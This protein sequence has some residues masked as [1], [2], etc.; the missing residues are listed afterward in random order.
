MK[1]VKVMKSVFDRL[2]S[3]LGSYSLKTAKNLSRIQ[4]GIQPRGIAQQPEDPE[5]PNSYVPYDQ[6]IDYRSGKGKKETLRN[7]DT[8]LL[9]KDLNY[10]NEFEVVDLFREAEISEKD[11]EISKNL[12]K[13]EHNIKHFREVEKDL[14]KSVTADFLMSKYKTTDPDTIEEIQRDWV[15][16]EYELRM[17]EEGKEVDFQGIRY[18]NYIKDHV[19]DLHRADQVEI[20]KLLLNHPEEKRLIAEYGG[21]IP[22]LVN[23]FQQLV[24][25]QQNFRH[26]SKVGVNINRKYDVRDVSHIYDGFFESVT[27]SPNS[28]RM[29]PPNLGNID[30]QYLTAKVSDLRY[31]YVVI[32]RAAYDIGAIDTDQKWSRHRTEDRHIEN[33]DSRNDIVNFIRHCCLVA[34]ICQKEGS[35]DMAQEMK[36]RP[37]LLDPIARILI[38]PYT[39]KSI[40]EKLEEIPS[41]LNLENPNWVLACSKNNI[42]GNLP[43]SFVEPIQ[44]FLNDTWNSKQLE[45]TYLYCMPYSPGDVH[46]FEGIGRDH[47]PHQYNLFRN[48]RSGETRLL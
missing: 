23:K 30:T 46:I 32:S 25:E 28:Q 34:Y 48:D 12:E 11:S 6:V 42:K 10:E 7:D 18:L 21:T 26:T 45:G 31:I 1:G 5:M 22:Q 35:E 4:H 17:Q 2:D 27:G 15:R 3:I 36:L 8:D 41:K 16:K 20:E 33:G 9:Y 40:N 43:A 14:L 44:N 47:D 13:L 24:F 29:I 39:P 38:K 37:K 19:W